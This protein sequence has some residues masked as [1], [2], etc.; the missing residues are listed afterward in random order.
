MRMQHS[1]P[2]LAG[3]GLALSVDV[4]YVC[5]QCGIGRIFIL[6]LMVGSHTAKESRIN[7]HLLTLNVTTM[8]KYTHNNGAGNTP[9]E[10]NLVLLIILTLTKILV[11]VC[12]L[13]ASYM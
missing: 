2:L 8:K 10:I 6:R 11:A 12:M 5:Y 7:T 4:L 9:T 3:M 1:T 13:L